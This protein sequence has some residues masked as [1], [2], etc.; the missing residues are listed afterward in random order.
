VLSPEER[1]A[2]DEKARKK[3]AERA[4]VREGRVSKL[5]MSVLPSFMFFFI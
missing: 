5:S 3:S 4:A 1:A 2:R